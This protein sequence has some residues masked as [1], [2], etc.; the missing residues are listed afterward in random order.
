MAASS[1]FAEKNIKC[2]DADSYPVILKDIYRHK[3][4]KNEKQKEP[5]TRSLAAGVPALVFFIRTLP[6]FENVI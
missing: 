6:S 4:N 3:Y 1:D 5:K 2:A